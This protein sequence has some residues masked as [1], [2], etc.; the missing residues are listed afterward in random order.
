MQ[1]LNIATQFL[2]LHAAPPN[3]RRSALVPQRPTARRR[4][5]HETLAFAEGGQR[6]VDEEQHVT[7]PPLRGVEQPALK[8]SA[9]L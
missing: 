8:V 7:L 6:S 5:R 1:A 2:G 9:A 3:S 4:T